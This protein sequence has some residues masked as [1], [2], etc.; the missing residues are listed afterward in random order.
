[1]DIYDK[2][3]WETGRHKLPECLSVKNDGTS[4]GIPSI[5]QCVYIRAM[6]GLGSLG[7]DSVSIVYGLMVGRVVLGKE[8]ASIYGLW[9]AWDP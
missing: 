3:G 7:K 4:S 1:M 9:L 6:V 2:V 8:S 5:G